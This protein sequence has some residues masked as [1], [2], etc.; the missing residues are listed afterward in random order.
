MKMVIL[1]LL[2]DTPGGFRMRGTEFPKGKEVEV[3]A[4]IA[5]L[6]IKALPEGSWKVVKG[7]PIFTSAVPATAKAI[8]R[9]DAAFRALHP[10]DPA[11]AL[12]AIT[13]LSK[14]AVALVKEPDAALL[15][16]IDAG[17]LDAEA[18]NAALC[19]RVLGRTDLAIAL[20]RRLK[21]V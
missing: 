19:L 15:K 1:M 11:K 2:L 3:S 6:A 20:C 5:G 16:A 13:P 7:E 18:G 21:A 10:T 17:K 8:A 14:D 12:E 4:E 9:Q